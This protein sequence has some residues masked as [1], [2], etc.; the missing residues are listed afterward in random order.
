MFTL[1]H[2]FLT[3]NLISD[4]ISLAV[5]ILLQ[6]SKDEHK[7]KSQL[8]VDTTFILLS[9]LMIASKIVLIWIFMLKFAKPS[10]SKFF[11]F[12]G[13]HPQRV[14]LYFTHLILYRLCLAVLVLLTNTVNLK[15]RVI[16]LMLL[17]LASLLWHVKKMYSTRLLYLQIFVF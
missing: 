6:I 3:E 8:L 4:L 17:Q 16:L 12:D 15:A 14:K 7:S 13:I 11:L 1:F 10:S 5:D 2:R 9:A